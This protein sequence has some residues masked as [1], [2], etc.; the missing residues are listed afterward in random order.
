MKK[1]ALRIASPCTLDWRSLTPAQGGRFCGDCKKVVRDI[2]AM[3]EA[4]ARAVLRTSSNAELCVR[5]V[6]DRDGRIVFANGARDASLVPASLLRRAKRFATTA[7]AIA[8]P[9]AVAACSFKMPANESQTS[10]RPS[11]HSSDPNDP[12]DPSY[13]NENQ[14]N[15]GGV[16]YDP[17][18][19]APYDQDAS[20]DVVLVSP[21]AGPT[22]PDASQPDAGD[23][24]ASPDAQAIDASEGETGTRI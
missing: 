4:E 2:S 19:D 8:A 17:D 16:A 24:N 10:S 14:E 1:E 5:Y 13:P 7:A 9:L 20:A 21:D 6:H 22:D 15:M 23:D 11:H 12:N 3:S 18:A